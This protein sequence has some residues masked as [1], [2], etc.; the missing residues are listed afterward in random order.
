V[1]HQEAS[2][3]IRLGIIGTGIAARVLH[4]P[5]LEKLRDQFEIVA[6]AN[7]TLSKAADFAEAIGT[8]PRITSDYREM[9]SWPEVEA[10]DIAVPIVM[11][12]MV[13]KEALQ[14][15]K[16]VIVEKPIAATV[17]A[18]R[19]VVAEARR[20]PNLVLL[21][22]EN[23]RYES[24]LRVAQRFLEEGRIGHVVMI[25]TDVLA[26]LDPASD[27]AGRPWRMYPEHL[28]GYLSDGGVHRTAALH[29]LAGRVSLVQGLVTSFDRN[30]HPTDTLLAN[31]LFTSGV[32]GH[33]TYSVGAH[34]SEPAPVRV[35]GSRGSLTAHYD[36]IVLA[37]SEGEEETSV[38]PSPTGFELE[39][40]DFYRSITEGRAPEASP[41]DALDDL[42]VIDAVLRSAHKGQVIRLR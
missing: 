12:A 17:A 19:S 30:R 1:L 13:A 24:R 35:Y 11:S 20:H 16:H 28:G 4:W 14:A 22:A 41:Q 34:G 15:G 32:V 7:R 39:F 3:S 10:V 8:R 40:A 33:L 29:M 42:E 21:V 31:L 37:T 9:L 23:V 27:I 25:H 36:R 6:L 26:P 2:L 38:P 18:A 5:A